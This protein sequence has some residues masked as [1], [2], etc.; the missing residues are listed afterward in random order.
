MENRYYKSDEEHLYAVA[1]V[2]REE[3]QAIVAAGFMVQ[4]DDPRLMMN[5]MLN[6]GVTVEQHRAGAAQRIAAL[7]PF[8]HIVDAA[9]ASFR[10]DLGNSSLVI[11]LV[12]AA[13]LAVVGLAVATRTFQ[14]ESA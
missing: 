8:S 7:N 1:E 13:V 5:Y 11:G 14:R 2:L 4:I 9:R 12:C 10:N 3:Y 6:P